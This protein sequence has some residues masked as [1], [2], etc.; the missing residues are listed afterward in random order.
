MKR[1]KTRIVDTR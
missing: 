1:K